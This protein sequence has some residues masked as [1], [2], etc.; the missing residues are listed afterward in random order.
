MLGSG[1]EA[2]GPEPWIKNAETL[3]KMRT[4][5]W[6]FPRACPFDSGNSPAKEQ[7]KSRMAGLFELPK[8]GTLARA[9]PAKL[10][11]LGGW[12]SLLA[13]IVAPADLVGEVY[14]ILQRTQATHKHKTAN[15]RP[16][17]L[18]KP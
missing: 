6:Q 1:I 4:S 10:Q 5:L 16:R 7:Q 3:A 17:S 2:T 13:M 8:P 14:K 12:K 15:P 9:S 11:W 18:P